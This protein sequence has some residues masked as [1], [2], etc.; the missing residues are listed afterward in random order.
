[1]KKKTRSI[2]WNFPKYKGRYVY[3]AVDLQLGDFKKIERINRRLNKFYLNA[4]I[5]HTRDYDELMAINKSLT[6]IIKIYK[7]GFINHS[8]KAQ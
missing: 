5:M 6:K 8:V 2:I 4:E 1:M 7:Q 3:R